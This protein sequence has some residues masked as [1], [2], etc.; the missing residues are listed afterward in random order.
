[1]APGEVEKI[2]KG[3]HEMG[4]FLM[5]TRR[6]PLMVGFFRGR[7]W[8]ET[9]PGEGPIAWPPEGRVQTVRAGDATQLHN[10]FKSNLAM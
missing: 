9:T 10:E 1:M 5:P 8:T 7:V 3:T 2:T 6:E 4:A